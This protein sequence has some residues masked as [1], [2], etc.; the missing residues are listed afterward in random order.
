MESIRGI[1]PKYFLILKSYWLAFIFEMNGHILAALNISKNQRNLLANST[2]SA[3]P[4][5]TLKSCLV[6]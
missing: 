4:G 6:M 3:P 5:K 2:V 1:G